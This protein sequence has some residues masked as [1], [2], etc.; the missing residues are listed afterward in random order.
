[1]SKRTPTEP[2]LDDP[3]N[4]VEPPSK[5]QRKRDAK[6]VQALAARLLASRPSEIRKLDLPEPILNAI[7]E[8]SAITRFGARKR[9]TQF[10]AKM[11]RNEADA[12]EIE[13]LLDQPAADA[14]RPQNT[15]PSHAHMVALL[16]EEPN[17]GFSRLRDDY[18][19]LER[20]RVTQ[21]LRQMDSADEQGRNAARGTLL[22][23]LDRH[24]R[25]D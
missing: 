6:A 14:A 3:D 19:T 22:T 8:G 4:A 23:L 13:K 17:A 21:L 24:H 20:Q 10:L 9:H 1:M 11:L 12:D 18:P 2:T 15:E 16:T 5:S 7:A 25:P